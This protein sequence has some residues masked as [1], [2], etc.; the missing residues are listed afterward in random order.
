MFIIFRNNMFIILAIIYSMFI[1]L[2]NN[3]SNELI[4]YL[5]FSYLYVL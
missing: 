2:R 3:M 4:I 1:I 5:L